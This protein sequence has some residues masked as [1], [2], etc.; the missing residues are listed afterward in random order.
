MKKILLI[1]IL[2]LYSFTAITQVNLNFETGNFTGW[3]GRVGNTNTGGQMLA[4]GSPTIW[5]MGVNSSI[6][7]QSY[8]TITTGAGTDQFGG[9][10]IVAPGGSYSARLG[11]S[12]PNVN[13]G[14]GCGGSPTDYT[15]PIHPGYVGPA[16]PPFS[17]AESLEQSFVVTSANCIVNLQY[18]AVFNNGSHSGAGATVNPFFRAEVLDAGGASISNCLTYT[19]V[20]NKSALPSGAA[21]SPSTPCY[22]PAPS[23]SS[24][25]VYMPWQRKIFDLTAQIGQTVTVKFT[26]GGC[27]EGGHFGYAYIDAS[28][29]PKD[30]IQSGGS[31][32]TGPKVL[33]GPTQYGS[34]YTWAGPAGGITASS[35]NQATVN[36]TGTYSMTVGTGSCAIVFT[37]FVNLSSPTIT[38]T[39][40][41]QSV[42]S[43]GNI[44]GINFTPSP[45]G[46]S[47]AW[48][49]TN[50]SVG[51]AA[52]GSGSISAYTSPT[53][54][55]QQIA[56]ITA[57][58]TFSGCTGPAK[59]FT[60]TIN[61]YPNLVVSA[62]PTIT[63]SSTTAVLS[64][65]ST[66]SGATYAWSPGGSA[67]TNSSTTVSA[68]GTYTL[69]TS[70]AGC[71]TVS[72][73]T[74]NTNT[75]VPNASA[76]VNSTITCSANTTTLNGSSSTSGV[77]YSWTPGGSTPTNSTTTVSSSG[78]YTLSVTDPSNGCRTATVV[79]VSQNTT[80]PVVANASSAALNCT[81]TSV[82]ASA[83]TST[84]P[85]SYNWSGAGIT[86]ATNISTITVN[87]PGTYNY[88][89]TNTSNG[90]ITTGSQA[91]TQN[92]TQPA[93]T[94][95]L[96]TVITCTSTSATL[97]GGPASGV[98]YSWSGA[99]LSGPTNLATATVTNTG[100]YTL[101]TTSTVN[102]CTNTAVVSATANITPPNISVNPDITLNCATV[103][104]TLS[105]ISTT[106]GATYSWT[107]PASG[108]PAGSTP[109]NST[110]VVSAPGNYTLTVT[111][112]ANGCTNSLTQSVGQNTI[113][114]NITVGS[115]QTITCAST[116]AVLT[117]STT[118]NPV[119]YS[120]T[121]PTAGTP[122]GSTPTNS[123]T[124]V[125]AGGN[126]TLT[127]TD[128]ANSCTTAAVVA[129]I[130]NTVT[131]VATGAVSGVLNCTLTSVNASA[132]T[133]MNPVSYTW[134]G[135]GITSATNIST[136]TAN[137]PGTFN[138]TVTN[139]SNGCSTTGSQSITQNTVA[140]N[141]T[142]SATQTITCASPTVSIMGSANPSSCT[143]VWTGG[144]CAGINSYTA[145]ACSPG[146][147]TLTITN[148]A[149]GCTDSDI[150]D[151]I[152]SIGVPVV[153]ASNNGSIT[154]TTNT[155][156]VVASTTATPVSYSWSG[157]GAVTGA[158][159]ANGTVTVGGTYQCV[160]TNTLT[161]CSSTITTVVSTD[162]TVP[163]PLAITGSTLTCTTQT[164]VLSS[165]PTGA[166]YAYTWTGPG[167]IAG[168]TTDS[169]TVDAGGDY[170]VTVTNTVNGCTGTT[171]VNAPTNTTVPTMT[172]TPSSVTTTCAAPTVTLTASSSTDPAAS[173]TWTAP[174]TGTLDNTNVSNP[175]A[176]GYGTFTVQVTNTLTGCVSAIETVSV[177]ADANTPVLNATAS[178]TTICDG[179]TSV[180]SITGADTYS[181]STTETAGTITVTPT[182]TTTY[183]VVGTNT[184]SG[185]T[186]T[187]NVTVNVTPT[188][189]V[190]IAASSQAI[191]EGNSA[192]LTL[193]G[194]TNYT[195][196][197]PSQ[198]TTSTIVVTPTVQTTY[199]VTGESLGCTSPTAIVTIDV[200]A[201]PQIAVTNQT[202]CAGIAVTLTANN[203]D[204]YNWMPTGTAT[205]TLS[206]SPT[207]NT[208]Y[209]VTGTNT[210]TG[211]TSTL[212][213]ADV[214][215]NQLPT[216]TANANP[217]TTCTSGTVNL[218]ASNTGT[219]AISNYTWTTGNGI[220]ITNQNQSN[221]SFPATG[222]T[223]GMY[224]Y[225]VTVT[226]TDNCVSLPATATLNIID[227]PNANFDLSDLSICQNDNGTI[228]INVPQ[229]GAI[230]DWSIN[231][232][233]INNTNPLTVPNSITSSSGTYTVSVIA[234]IGSC[235]N[236]AA[237]TL[238]VNALPTIDLVNPMVS[239]CEN[240]SAG[241]AVANPTTTYNY[242]WTYGNQT[243]GNGSTLN[244][245]PLTQSN[246]GNY[247]VTVTDNNGCQN[248]TIGAIDAQTCEIYIPEIF[249]PNG[250]G[251]NDG[252]VI[253]N[254]ENYPDNKLKIFNR[255]GN[256]I[257]QK[258]SYM[259]EF[260]G[261]ANTGDQVGKAKLPAGT[262][263]VILEYGDNKTETYNG[264]LLLQY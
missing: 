163:T 221:P 248:R 243:V 178:N 152:P 251:K 257:Y 237:N 149:N 30:L 14:G 105:G 212:T 41:N 245:N 69:T 84:T 204:T 190:N 239:A 146:T 31:G 169:P 22:Y 184:L 16:I 205:N 80:A 12:G 54:T 33:T 97:S 107:G 168:S 177:T 73:V 51:L 92:T 131:P 161:G 121:G 38:A 64:G 256:L 218:T 81:L 253:R 209:S 77:T 164:I 210:L 232:Q 175:T 197:N 128:P 183:T 186:N 58:P 191:C 140:P 45:A 194:A 223:P 230:Y 263:Y 180:L 229:S 36:A 21:Q 6:W 47:I 254:I 108:S 35:A 134:S 166:N 29:G 216:I 222:L 113:T 231:G 99:G 94:A 129:I 93:A 236:T 213:T 227:I 155:I 28:S 132:T 130:Q 87:Q 182:N 244:V 117:G 160:V 112:P 211:C 76:T 250:D 24:V 207:G 233:S 151:V 173:Y 49:N 255:W 83:T 2:S 240:T 156:E 63:C 188:P 95:S 145:S 203:A 261:Y 3:T 52:S 139:T 18:A 246:A 23:T 122:A 27:D 39:S 249:T 104:N 234:G 181:W 19:F 215:V 34:S 85:V 198:T 72:V 258:D 150:V 96:A 125:S 189:T 133:T 98:I 200:N 172:L 46:S 37:T 193:T 13:N 4:V 25:V 247:T 202:T 179:N 9:F 103:S 137:Q 79:S 7:N 60:I 15:C 100:S 70:L 187:T 136:V 157:P 159:T 259:N 66:T 115:T 153:T 135:A 126:Y 154:C 162:T 102:G 26:S 106:P 17:G 143:P 65:T 192:T 206:V 252:F 11:G 67:P 61:P 88:T 78:N 71:S 138:Y 167:V 110:S 56:V 68:G 111:N 82:N 59:T 226:S 74:V 114:P 20:L 101:T 242:T 225:T 118:T 165:T 32:C 127:L 43:G 196:T 123:N 50:I 119:G 241:L 158:A 208:T 147:Y 141:V 224:V 238:T 199:T 1:C 10:P 55:S 201:L 5:T 42:C 62:N 8:H 48:A 214:T 120:W 176:G 228:S 89:V 40:S 57:T 219:T 217:G 235:T 75:T 86:S 144:A 91:V 171:T 124:T 148:P 220:D 264:Y 262:Y 174:G 116:T 260:E 90:C 53:V 195:I 109:T 170:A 185:C 44:S 142:V